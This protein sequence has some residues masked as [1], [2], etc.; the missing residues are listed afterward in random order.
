MMTEEKIQE[1]LDNLRTGVYDTP[2]HEIECHTWNTGSKEIEI[3]NNETH[4]Y[5]TI[6]LHNCKF[7]RFLWKLFRKKVHSYASIRMTN[8]ITCV[9]EEILISNELYESFVAYINER[10]EQDK[11]IIRSNVESDFKL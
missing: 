3:R 8:G 11:L 4:L 7:K 5:T 9:N 2:K 6:S 10:I 1:L